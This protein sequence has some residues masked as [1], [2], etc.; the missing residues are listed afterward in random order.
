VSLVFTTQALPIANLGTVERADT[1]LTFLTTPL[2]GAWTG[3]TWT[4][5]ES[6]DT[7][8][9]TNTIVAIRPSIR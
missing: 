5:G 6:S 4:S 1:T 7:A 3:G 9:R 2:S 8:R